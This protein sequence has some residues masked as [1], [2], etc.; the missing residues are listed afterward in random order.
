MVCGALPAVPCY[1][2]LQSLKPFSC[3]VPGSLRIP[4]LCSP[5]CGPGNFAGGPGAS[6]R[7]ADPYAYR[8]GVPWT[9]VSSRS[10]GSV[11]MLCDIVLPAGTHIDTDEVRAMIGFQQNN[12]PFIG[13]KGRIPGSKNVLEGNEPEVQGAHFWGPWLEGQR[14]YFDHLGVQSPLADPAHSRSSV[15]LC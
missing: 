10:L 1:L 5:I 14:H 7:R 2:C 15:R 4:S 9:R 6:R 12:S 11:L 3:H 8:Q 13:P